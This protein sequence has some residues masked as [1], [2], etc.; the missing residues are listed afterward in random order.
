MIGMGEFSADG[1]MGAVYHSSQISYSLNQFLPGGVLSSAGKNR[2]QSNKATIITTKFRGDNESMNNYGKLIVSGDY[3]DQHYWQL[4]HDA[5]K[6]RLLRES[7]T[8]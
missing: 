6:S 3:L 7:S 1:R 2:S 5:A 4:F 8:K